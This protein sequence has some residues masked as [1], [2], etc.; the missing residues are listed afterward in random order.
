MA[1]PF[2]MGPGGP[3]YM[4]G[5]IPQQ[6]AVPQQ[7]FMVSQVQQQAAAAPKPQVPQISEEKLQEKCKFIDSAL[8]SMVIYM[9]S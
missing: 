8:G 4:V 6:I 7:Q 2:F 5:G 3:V 9:C 1:N